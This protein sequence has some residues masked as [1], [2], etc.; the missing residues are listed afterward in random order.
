MKGTY[1][2]IAFLPTEARISVGAL[3]AQVFPRGLYVYV[4]S[5]LRGIEN[6][7][8]RH[9]SSTKNVRWHIDY[10]LEKADILSTV[11]IPCEAKQVECEVVRALLKCE[12]ARAL[13]DGFG[14]SDCRCGS[15]LLYFGDRDTEWVL[16]TIS[17]H[18]SM[19]ACMYP[20]SVSKAA[21]PD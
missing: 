21:N 11:A 16:E 18:L 15:H 9:K 5:A 20:R 1:C 7:V 13:I 3:G 2:L 14:S 12:G 8:R 17:M 4:G 10:F 6:R 19:L